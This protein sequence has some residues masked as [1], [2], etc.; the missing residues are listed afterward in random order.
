MRVLVVLGLRGAS[1]SAANGSPLRSSPP[2]AARAARSGRST[3]RY[4]PIVPSSLERFLVGAMNRNP[5]PVPS[6]APAF[7]SIPGQTLSRE[8]I[9]MVAT[10]SWVPPEGVAALP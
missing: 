4:A 2:S 10:N 6:G 3:H 9:P 7:T 1:T 8:R 5:R